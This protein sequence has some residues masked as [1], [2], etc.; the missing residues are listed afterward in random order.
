LR[1]GGLFESLFD[2]TAVGIAVEDLEGRPLFAN[3]ALCSLLG[4]TEEE[5]RRKHCQEFSPPED[6]Q[7]DWALFEELRQGSID[8]YL[9]EKRFFRKDGTIFWGRL[10]VSLIRDRAGSSPLVVALVEDITEKKAAE[11]DLQRSEASLQTLA[12]RLLQIQEEEQRRIGRELHDDL[13]QRLSLLVLG[14]EELRD[15]LA[16]AGQESSQLASELHRKAGELATDIH[17]LSHDLHSAKVDFLGLHLAL[18]SLCEKISIKQHISII[19][20]AEELPANSPPGLELCIFRIAQEALNNAVKHS[21][22]SEVFVELTCAV[23]TIILKVRDLGVGFDPA[24]A[25]GGI[26]LST[27]RERLRMFGG[28]LFVESIPGKGTAI[29]AKVKLE[30]AK[31]AT[32][33]EA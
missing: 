8:N 7:K 15:G 5:L 23:D 32:T 19:L 17:N 24:T 3:P 33:G 12:S 2:A 28:G 31:A 14:L 30:M 10:R 27:M 11:T 20:H 29:V 21:H 18:R 16:E 6:A 9:L 22:A 1:E 4:F 26:G 25:N 13:G